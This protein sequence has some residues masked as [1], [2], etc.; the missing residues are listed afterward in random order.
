MFVDMGRGSPLRSHET[1]SMGER[2]SNGTGCRLQARNFISRL[3]S[4]SRHL[5]FL[6]ATRTGTWHWPGKNCFTRAWPRKYPSLRAPRLGA[7]LGVFSTCRSAQ[8]LRSRCDQLCHHAVCANPPCIHLRSSFRRGWF[9]ARDVEQ[10]HQFL[11][12]ISFG[13]DA[14]FSEEKRRPPRISQELIRA[15]KPRASGAEAGKLRGAA[16]PRVFSRRGPAGRF[17]PRSPSLGRRRERPGR[18]TNRA[19]QKSRAP[20]KM[21]RRIQRKGQPGRHRR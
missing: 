16:C 7:V 12:V 15:T 21:P 1:R 9:Q 4:S 14:V 19:A 13:G 3:P 17:A 18:E 6:I 2:A 11:L 10:P 8:A 5:H 20:Q